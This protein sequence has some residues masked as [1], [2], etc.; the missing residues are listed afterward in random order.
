MVASAY[1]E[2]TAKDNVFEYMMAT[3][4]LDFN[5]QFLED[6]LYIFCDLGWFCHKK[7][8]H[9]KHC[10]SLQTFLTRISTL[11]EITHRW[12]VTLESPT[13]RA[14]V[15]YWQTFSLRNFEENKKEQGREK[16]S[17]VTSLSILCEGFW[18][19]CE[20]ISALCFVLK[21]KLESLVSNVKMSRKRNPCYIECSDCSLWSMLLINILFSI[22]FFKWIFQSKW[23]TIGNIS[24]SFV[25]FVVIIYC[26]SIDQF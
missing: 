8:E 12:P 2:D 22:A 4:T 26:V 10:R 6:C 15:I 5:H 19:N 23:Q 7:K 24:I 1:H 21:H 17:V 18:R 11:R 3:H 9:G 20:T 16:N 25:H 13:D 14:N